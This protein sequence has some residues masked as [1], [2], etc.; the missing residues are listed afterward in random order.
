MEDLGRQSPKS[1]SYSDRASRAFT[2]SSRRSQRSQHD[3]KANSMRWSK[4]MTEDQLFPIRVGKSDPVRVKPTVSPRVSHNGETNTSKLY[5]MESDV[6]DLKK[7]RDGILPP[8]TERC[9]TRV[10]PTEAVHRA[11]STQEENRELLAKIGE[12]PIHNQ[13]N[14]MCLKVP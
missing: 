14:Y 2:M 4:T 11:A 5:Y 9:L 12:L 1:Q 10:T 8:Q 7:E 13:A 3:S 6:N